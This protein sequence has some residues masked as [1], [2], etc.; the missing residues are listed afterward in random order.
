VRG[1]DYLPPGDVNFADLAR[2]VLASD[3]ASHPDS[4]TQR[5]WLIEEFVTRGIVSAPKE[6]DVETNFNHPALRGL[7]IEELVASDFAA[8]AFAQ[9][10]S[11][12]LNIPAETPFEVRPRLDVEKLYWHEEGKGKLREVLFKVSWSEIEPNRTGHGLPKKRRYRAGTTLAIGLD[13]AKPQCDLSPAFAKSC[14]VWF[15]VKIAVGSVRIPSVRVRGESRR[16]LRSVPATGWL[17][18]C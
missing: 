1:L 13:R 16:S 5:K 11:A 4:A 18:H 15:S 10:N 17:S 12:W 8:Y 9:R 2:A 6:L 7:D 14:V 3:E